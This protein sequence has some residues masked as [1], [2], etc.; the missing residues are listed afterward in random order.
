MAQATSR[1]RNGKGTTPFLVILRCTVALLST[2]ALI[3]SARNQENAYQ[4]AAGEFV[5]IQIKSSDDPG[6][7]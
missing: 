4:L 1:G 3:L 7:V 5:L 2:A 6:L